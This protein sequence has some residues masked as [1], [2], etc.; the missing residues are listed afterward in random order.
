MS[1]WQKRFLPS[2]TLYQTLNLLLSARFL[3][4]TTINQPLTAACKSCDE[5]LPVVPC[6]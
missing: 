6:L 3:P 2:T 1:V 4:S 5:S